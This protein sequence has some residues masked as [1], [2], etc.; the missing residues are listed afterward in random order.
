MKQDT[1]MRLSR[2]QK[3]NQRPNRHIISEVQGGALVHAWRVPGG[4]PIPQWSCARWC[5][6]ITAA[7]PAL[8]FSRAIEPTQ[9]SELRCYRPNEPSI[10][11]SEAMDSET[12]QVSKRIL[13][14][15]LLQMDDYVAC[16]QRQ[17]KDA[18][19]DAAIHRDRWQRAF[20]RF[21]RP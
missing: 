20:A 11:N 4:G 21:P 5:L 18:I 9:A 10:P 16:L 3:T 15:Y 19:S 2:V 8:L 17:A 13:D 1:R 14:S 6:I 12:L 7:A